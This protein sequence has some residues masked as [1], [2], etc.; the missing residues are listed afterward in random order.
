MAGDYTVFTDTIADNLLSVLISIESTVK[1]SM[2]DQG[3]LT[4]LDPTENFWDQLLYCLENSSLKFDNSGRVTFD[5]LRLYGT[6]DTRWATSVT[7][8]E[9][10]IQQW[11]AIVDRKRAEHFAKTKR[12]TPVPVERDKDNEQIQ[13]LIHAIQHTEY[14][15]FLRQYATPEYEQAQIGWI[16]GLVQFEILQSPTLAGYHQIYVKHGMHEVSSTGSVDGAKAYLPQAK[17]EIREHMPIKDALAGNYNKRFTDI[18][19][20]VEAIRPA[21]IRDA[22]N[23]MKKL[24]DARGSESELA[25]VEQFDWDKYLNNLEQLTLAFDFEGKP[26]LPQ[27]VTSDPR[28]V[29]MT[30]AQTLRL[31]RI[32]EEKWKENNARRTRRRRL[33]EEY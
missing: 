30:E 27:V 19:E 14:D 21:L 9:V 1:Q 7:P 2:Q 22:V 33:S 25:I 4:R 11:Q 29:E 3:A 6:G 23:L 13:N 32:I 17:I 20:Q 5:H 28:L 10:Q 26:T 24:H 18:K 8:T 16:K 31:D 12:N 15:Q